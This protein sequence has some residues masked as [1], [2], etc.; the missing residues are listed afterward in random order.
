MTGTLDD[1]EMDLLLQKE[2]VVRVGFNDGERTY[3]IPICYVYRDGCLYAHSGPGLKIDALRSGGEPCFQVDHIDDL[4]NWQSVMAWGQYEELA[5]DDAD[6]AVALLA[7]RFAPLIS[8][9]G[10]EFPHPWDNHHGTVEHLLHRAGRHG[11]VFR[12][13]VTHR[14]GRYE[15]R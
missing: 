9:Q 11:V 7:E 1:H 8:E 13:K 4:A 10:G 15:K 12:V 3:V 14:T 2:V 6:R 5:G